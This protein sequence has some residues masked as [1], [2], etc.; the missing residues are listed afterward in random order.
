MNII[1][2][3]VGSEFYLSLGL[4]ESE[5]ESCGRMEE[6]NKIYVFHQFVFSYYLCF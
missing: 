2:V 5:F 4:R 6:K 3:S 1:S